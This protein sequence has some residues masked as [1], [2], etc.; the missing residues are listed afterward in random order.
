MQ[1]PRRHRSG[2]FALWAVAWVLGG[3]LA[4][5]GLS[6]H[7]TGVPGHDAHRPVAETSM[8]VG[9]SAAHMTTPLTA[10]MSVTAPGV[11]DQG[12]LLAAC[13]VVLGLALLVSLG[14]LP[15]TSVRGRA[16]PLPGPDLI[17]ARARDP[18][19]PDLVRLSICRC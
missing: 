3:L 9:P 11:P 12:H 7:G 1:G 13:L 15:L 16:G 5:H 18:A 19:P 17:L 2:Q 10:P 6:S 14:V 8:A 4:M